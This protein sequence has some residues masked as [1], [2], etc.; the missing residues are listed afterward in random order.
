M[1]V[2]SHTE[3]DKSTN[4]FYMVGTTGNMYSRGDRRIPDT[5]TFDVTRFGGMWDLSVTRISSE[6]GVITGTVI[7]YESGFPTEV[8]AMDAA[9]RHEQ[10]AVIASA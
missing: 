6:N 10:T 9:N 3:N 1:P 7:A 8:D 4:M 2:S 5:L